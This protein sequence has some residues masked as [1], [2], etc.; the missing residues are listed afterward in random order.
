MLVLIRL[1]RFEIRCSSDFSPLLWCVL[2]LIP[3]ECFRL[4]SKM[5]IICE[6]LQISNKRFGSGNR[7]MWQRTIKLSEQCL[8]A[9]FNAK[10]HSKKAQLLW[11]FFY[12]AAIFLNFLLYFCNNFIVLLFNYFY[13]EI[14]LSIFSLSLVEL[15]VK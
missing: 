11:V 2:V 12:S 6:M 7:K 4:Y 5:K 1:F 9:Y 14:I 3:A 13:F 8:I 15:S 10:I